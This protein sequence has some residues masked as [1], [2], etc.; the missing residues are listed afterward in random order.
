MFGSQLSVPSFMR[1]SIRPYWSG[2]SAGHSIRVV[3]EPHQFEPF[4]ARHCELVTAGNRLSLPEGFLVPCWSLWCFGAKTR[5]YP[6]GPPVPGVHAVADLILRHTVASGRLFGVRRA[7]PVVGMF[8]CAHGATEIVHDR[9]HCGLCRGA[10][11]CRRSRDDNA[12]VKRGCNRSLA[13]RN[14]VPLTSTDCFGASVEVGLALCMV[15]SDY[16]HRLGKNV[17]A[18]DG[19]TLDRF[20]KLESQLAVEFCHP[21]K[22][23]ARFALSQ[24]TATSLVLTAGTK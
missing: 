10:T 3:D 12:T 18:A 1:S 23:S 14:V 19:R 20:A 13:R 2:F 17:P 22:N 7:V 6:P 24:K 5:G 9:R 21:A 11:Y 15:A 16:R 8:V 4:I